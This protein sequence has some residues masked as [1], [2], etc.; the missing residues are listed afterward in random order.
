MEAVQA[1]CFGQKQSNVGASTEPEPQ[2]CHLHRDLGMGQLWNPALPPGVTQTPETWPRTTHQTLE[3]HW[4][5]SEGSG[6]A[7]NPTRKSSS[8]L[9][10]LA[11]HP[12]WKNLP[13]FPISRTTDVPA[14]E[15]FPGGKREERN[16]S[17]A[18][19]SL[20]PA[21][22]AIPS[23]PGALAAVPESEPMVASTPTMPVPMPAKLPVAFHHGTVIT[24]HRVVTT[25]VS[26]YPIS[27]FICFIKHPQ[28]LEL[29]N[30]LR[31]CERETQQR[32]LKSL[33]R[34]CQEQLQD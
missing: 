16:G 2:K 33:W 8:T 5:W 12:S 17:E 3:R 19:P 23:L 30:K 18:I 15:P 10:H 13:G 31:S 34:S 26:H 29:L 11:A 1:G 6:L 24:S 25:R 32:D 20:F 28:N 14:E 4:K 27:G 9:L 21:S 22:R 7:P